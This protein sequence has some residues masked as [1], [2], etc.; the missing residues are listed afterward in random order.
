MGQNC[1]VFNLILRQNEETFSF[2]RNDMRKVFFIYSM[3][4]VVCKWG[5]LQLKFSGSAYKD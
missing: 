5:C 2:K 3:N 1:E 4:G